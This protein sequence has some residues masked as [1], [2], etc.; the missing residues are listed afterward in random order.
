VTGTNR[1]ARQH[2]PGDSCCHEIA[3]RTDAGDLTIRAVR[4]GGLLVV[5]VEDDGPG[6]PAGWTF[7]PP[8]GSGVGLTM[9]ARGSSGCMEV[10]VDSS[11]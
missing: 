5:E 10:R 11:C 9:S 6:L 8:E 7:T 1:H 4:R 2:S 3:R